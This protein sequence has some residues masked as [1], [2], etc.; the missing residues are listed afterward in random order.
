MMNNELQRL[1]GWI[2]SL[3]VKASPVERRRLSRK[4]GLDLRRSQSVWITSQQNPD[5]TPFTP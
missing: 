4:I 5:G 3:L 1:E 2:G